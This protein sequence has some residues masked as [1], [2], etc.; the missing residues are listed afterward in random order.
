M[1][2]PEISLTSNDCLMLLNHTIN[3]LPD[4]LIT[5]SKGIFDSKACRA[6]LSPSALV[7]RPL[8]SALNS[9]EKSKGFVG[10]GCK[11]NT[12]KVAASAKKNKAPMLRLEDG[13]IS[14]LNHPA[15]NGERFSLIVDDLGIYYNATQPSRLEEWLN[16]AELDDDLLRRASALQTS[17]KKHFLSKYNHSPLP[18][19]EQLN[20]IFSGSSLLDSTKRQRILVIDQ[21]QNDCSIEYGLANEQSFS[22]MLRAAIDE[23]PEADIYVKLHPDVRFGKKTGY[24]T[25]TQ[26]SDRIK[27][28]TD[29]VN[30]LALLDQVDKVYTVTSQLGFEA[31]ILNKPVVCFGVPFYSGWGLTDDRQLCTRRKR[32]RDIHE[33]IALAYFVYPRYIHPYTQERCELEDILPI[34]IQHQKIK[35]EQVKNLFCI[36][37]SMWKKAFIGTF[38]SED[39][40]KVI[41]SKSIKSALKKIQPGDGLLV[42][43]RKLDSQLEEAKGSSAL[44]DDIPVWR[45][46]DGFIRSVGL[47][48]D[49]RRPS[50]LVID[51]SGIHFDYSTS[52]D[53]EKLLND[54]E[55]SEQELEQASTLREQLLLQRVS[56]YNVSDSTNDDLLSDLPED[57]TIILVPGQ[58]DSDASIQFGCAEINSNEKLLRQVKVNYP[59]A[60]ILYKPH[61]D[62]VSGN[63]EGSL[64]YSAM[65][66]YYSRLIIGGD[67]F[68]CIAR[69]DEVHTMTS[70]TGFE[71][72]LQGKKV[73]TY[74]APFYSGWGLTEDRLPVKRRQKK[75]TLNELISGALCLYPRYVD[76]ERRKLTQPE[77]VVAQI[78]QQKKAQAETKLG[79]NIITGRFNGV[80]RI[81][82]KAHYLVETIF[83]RT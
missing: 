80:F 46:E 23:N 40:D 9:K 31:L 45:M 54:H 67:I 81:V 7:Y 56:K 19:S 75:R 57:K 12:I 58:V 3:N 15:Q 18:S 52:S 8:L 63:R 26:A 70:L 53:L 17:I 50:S 42:W 39:A 25:E 44:S 20:A 6:L 24:L 73:V 49:L 5:A 36:D 82:R 59:D 76:W 47:G 68:D 41:F 32:K 72:L 62:V 28:I 78:S 1:R 34:L 35:S 65:N 29:N 83:Y 74:G 38:V 37:F 16:H 55:F 4:F 33:I 11:E 79:S 60:F 14:Y 61:P 64:D 66:H 77:V 43:G 71:A 2:P 30:P 51:K 48:V 10:W 27:L 22:E 21:T 13:F 69:C